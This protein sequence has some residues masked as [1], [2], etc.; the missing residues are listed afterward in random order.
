MKPAKILITGATGFIGARLCEILTLERGTPYR[1]LVRNF[2][3]AA[4]IAR[5]DAE[6][7]AGDLRDPSVLAEALAGCDAV[8]HLAHSDD[9]TAA[10]E[11]RNL[12]VA[13]QRARIRRFVHVSSMAVHG[14]A[15]QPKVLTETT[16][17]IQRWG[18]P[19][20]DAKAQS[21]AVVASAI[22]KKF[23]AV[24]LRPTVVYGPYS[25]FITP[26]IDHARE[27]RVCLIDG[28]RGLCNAVYVDDVC[29]AILAALDTERAVGR[30][31]FVN[32]DDRLTWGEFIHAFARLTGRPTRTC[33]HSVE[34]IRTHWRA[35][36]PT[37]ASNVRALVRLA[38]SPSLHAELST[39]PAV[40][41]LLRG[42]KEL[43]A[44]AVSEEHKWMLK[45][46]LQGAP[47]APAP[48]TSQGPGVPNESRVVREAYR[49]WVSNARAKQE[50]GWRPRTPFARGA[51]LTGAWL[52][53]AR[54][55]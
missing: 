47:R 38:A 40:G 23:P 22:E 2:T 52:Q 55:V 21:E 7:I 35:K 27:G 16:A 11:T 5:L 29:D 32:G 50:L 6:M 43:L 51:E 31:F 25:Y 33:D 14:P 39:V 26:I 12:V 37:L 44:G 28:G 17:P 1:A 9:R 18:E 46:R 8:V 3:R 15:P 36:R 10:K 41:A 49:S 53:F 4:R 34:E 54:M 45:G 30:T 48:T 24:I 42:T 13:C 20:S 19:Y